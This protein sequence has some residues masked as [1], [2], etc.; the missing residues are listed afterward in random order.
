[1][2]SRQLMASLL[3]IGKKTISVLFSLALIV[4][5]L[6]IVLTACSNGALYSGVSNA[7]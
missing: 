5:I 1:M 3:F 2:S 6:L 4:L 7:L